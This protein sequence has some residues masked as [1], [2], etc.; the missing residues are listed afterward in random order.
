MKPRYMP[1]KNLRRRLVGCGVGGI[2]VLVAVFGS[3]V[4]AVASPAMYTMT[5][6]GTLPELPSCEANAVNGLGHIVGSCWAYTDQGVLRHAFVWDSRRGIRAVDTPAGFA[7]STAGAINTHG[8]VVGSIS[9]VGDRSS[10]TS[11]PVV[12]PLSPGVAGT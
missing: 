7:N 9:D 12:G 5:D 3:G 2:A 11:Q 4:R 10:S 8:E 1:G 6:L